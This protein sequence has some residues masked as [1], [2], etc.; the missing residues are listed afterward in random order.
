MRANTRKSD[1]QPVFFVPGVITILLCVLA[2][3]HVLRVFL[4]PGYD[5][6]AVTMLGILPARYMPE[7][8]S[9]F[10]GGV[11]SA[12]PPF[13]TYA[14]LHAGF[15]H[16]AVNSAWLLA[17]G[18]AVARRL[19]AARFLIFYM[20]C[21]VLAAL[22]HIAVGWGSLT[23]M[24]GASGAI[25]GMMAAAFRIALLDIMEGPALSSTPRLLPLT[26]RRFLIL[27]GSWAF[28]NIVFGITGIRV[29]EQ[30]LMIAWDAHLAGFAAG[31]LLI[32]LF[33]RK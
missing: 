17:F 7:V 2:G 10:P 3:V 32:G 4:A 12:I 29:S 25:S 31:A 5:R 6:F 30:V 11:W 26:D 9:A 8:I 13:L 21:A 18:S 19:G 20:V 22:V 23:P 24:V 33:V 27:S 1:R 15:A 14:F 28:V 16:L